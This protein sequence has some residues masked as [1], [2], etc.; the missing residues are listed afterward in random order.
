MVVV[1]VAAPLSMFGTDML[2]LDDSIDVGLKTHAQQYLERTARTLTPAAA[3]MV[4][5][6]ALPAR[7]LIEYAQESQPGAIALA[8][9][10]RS[11]LARLVSGSVADKLLR[12]AE[13]PLLV[14]HPSA[15]SSVNHA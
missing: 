3:V 7:A 15:S 14:L 5:Q 12:G 9:H 1:P 6:D 8:T 11:G 13:Q 10:G 2:I 4:L